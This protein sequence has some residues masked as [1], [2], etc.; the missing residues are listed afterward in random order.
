MCK[1]VLNGE[2]IG[3]KTVNAIGN[4]KKCGKTIK[5]V[6]LHHFYTFTENV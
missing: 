5:G 6:N 4:I 2:K 3:K 1:N